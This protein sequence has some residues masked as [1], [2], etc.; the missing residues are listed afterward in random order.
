[1]RV[2]ER[3]L[4]TSVPVDL[5]HE[6]AVLNFAAS[7]LAADPNYLPWSA[8]AILLKDTREMVGHLRF[9]TRPDPEYLHPYVRNAVE[10]G[11]VIFTAHRR[12]GYAREALTRAM[13]WAETH[14][15][16]RFVAS[17]SPSNIPS[18]ALVAEAGF[19][20]IGEHIDSED[21]LDHI[22]LRESPP[23]S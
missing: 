2:I 18:L 19:C 9:H 15:V 8:R 17:I 5:R 23:N 11:Y 16:R 10:L 12:R 14:G 21:G 1:M 13:C 22:F 3:Q 7:Q 6:P 20:K 4:R